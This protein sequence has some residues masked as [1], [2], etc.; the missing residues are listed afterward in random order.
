MGRHL[1]M[2][3]LHMHLHL[4]FVIRVQSSSE[5]KAKQHSGAQ[6]GVPTAGSRSWSMT[7]HGVAR[8]PQPAVQT[9]DSSKH[10]DITKKSWAGLTERRPRQVRLKAPSACSVMQA[11][12]RDTFRVSPSAAR[13]TSTGWRT[14]AAPRIEVL[15]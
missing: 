10:S 11:A 2:M 4:G 13:S 3:H 14:A 15:S 1:L 8:D 7:L 12:R 9:L 6:V 5:P